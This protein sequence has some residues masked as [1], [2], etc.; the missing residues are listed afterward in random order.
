MAIGAVYRAAT[1]GT[2]L[3]TELTVQTSYWV[4]DVTGAGDPLLALRNA[5]IASY[6]PQIVR[7]STSELVYSSVEVYQVFPVKTTLQRESFVFVPGTQAPPSLPS[8]CTAVISKRT[9]IVGK[10]GRG[11]FFVPMIPTSGVVADMVQP[12]YAI[13][14]APVQAA[15]ISQIF[16]G[17][18]TFTPVLYSP[19]RPGPVPPP[20]PTSIFRLE[21]T[22]LN[23]VIR[24]QRRRELGVRIHG[25]RKATP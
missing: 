7:G 11:R 18:F 21:T 8:Q 10:S 22:V 23:T 16:S 24:T 13:L 15:I 17:G 19:L 2:M 25:R 1:I 5:L 3:G 4:E 20:R 6:I 12:A 14:L 9:A